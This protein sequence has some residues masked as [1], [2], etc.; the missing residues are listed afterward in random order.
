M[1]IATVQDN[2]FRGDS[3]RTRTKKPEKHRNKEGIQFFLLQMK[4]E[5]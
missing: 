5:L 3:I 4:W 1:K 2:P